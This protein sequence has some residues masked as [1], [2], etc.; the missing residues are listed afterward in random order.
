MGNRGAAACADIHFAATPFGMEPPH[1]LHCGPIPYL[2]QRLTA[3]RAQRLAIE[4]VALA[5]RVDIAILLD[6]RC[7][8]PEIVAGMLPLVA[9][10]AGIGAHQIGFVGLD[11]ELINAGG[12][13]PEAHE[14]V[15]P[16]GAA[17]PLPPPHNDPKFSTPP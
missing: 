16:P 6:V 5:A 11:A 4:H 8:A 2:D 9:G 7:A 13:A 14:L 1:L 10:V 15:R 17:L 12:R 3:D